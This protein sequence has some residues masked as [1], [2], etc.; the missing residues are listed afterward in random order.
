MKKAIFLAVVASL[1]LTGCFVPVNLSYDSAKTLDK[2]QLEVQGSWSQYN[3]MNDSTYETAKLNQNFG[4]SVGYGVTD[5]YTMKLR[6]EYISYNSVFRDIFDG[7]GSD[8]STDLSSLTSM[9]YFELNNKLRLYKHNLSVGLPL[10]FYVYNKS[11]LSNGEIG[12]GWI[13]FDPK[14][15]ISFFR[16][17][18]YFELT[19][20]PKAHIMFGNFGFY[21][22]LGISAGMGFSSN[23][24]RWAIRPEIGYDKFLSFGVGVNYNF[25]LIKPAGGS[26]AGK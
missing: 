9:S 23:L 13:C 22:Q 3:V 7:D 11:L 14:F 15:Y 20:I 25:N 24:D 1:F 21:G 18:K 12:L 16:K 10:G 4:G 5:K 8:L 17:S 19:V 2:G 6:Y 26:D